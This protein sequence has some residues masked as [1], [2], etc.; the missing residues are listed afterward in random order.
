MSWQSSKIGLSDQP[1]LSLILAVLKHSP[2]VSVARFYSIK[3]HL[4]AG[5]RLSDLSDTCLALFSN[6]VSLMSRASE[7]T[8]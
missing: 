3:S 4:L 7:N 8:Q 1:N 2:E 5:S 6:A